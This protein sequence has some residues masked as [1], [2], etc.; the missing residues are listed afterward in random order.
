MGLT[1]FGD[2][3]VG[4]L[5]ARLAVGVQGPGD[6]RPR[7]GSEPGAMVGVEARHGRHQG[8]H[9][10]LQG[11]VDVVAPEAQRPHPQ[12]RQ[13]QRPAQQHRPRVVVTP[14]R[15]DG[16]PVLLLRGECRLPQQTAHHVHGSTLGARPHRL[17]HDPAACG[18][19]P[20]GPA[21]AGGPGDYSPPKVRLRS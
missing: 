6:P 7:V 20:A 13:A 10:H 18:R 21:R 17:Q 5:R 9:G 8:Q 19:A 14:T 11:V 3:V 15:E 12:G 4:H 1:R 2:D 16:Q